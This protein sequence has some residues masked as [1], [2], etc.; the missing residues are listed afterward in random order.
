MWKFIQ[1]KDKTMKFQ[2]CWKI[3]KSCF[4]ED[5]WLQFTKNVLE[6]VLIN[7]LKIS[8]SKF[9]F[10]VQYFS[11]LGE[12]TATTAN[13]I[14]RIYEIIIYLD[15][16][17]TLTSDDGF[18]NSYND[19]LHNLT[20]KFPRKKFPTHFCA[21]SV[22]SSAISAQI[23]GVFSSFFRSTCV[24]FLQI[25]FPICAFTWVYWHAQIILTVRMK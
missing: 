7:I 1:K 22:R 17:L 18:S 21:P 12:K 23:A 14:D 10:Q 2:Q 8:N 3:Q 20:E 25:F 24:F 15:L 19:R 5:K 11:W 9:Q 6:D 16:F 13:V 4:G